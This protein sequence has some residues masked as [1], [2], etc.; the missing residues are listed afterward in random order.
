MK[1]K[2]FG[3]AALVAF[4]LFGASCNEQKQ[5]EFDFDSVTQEVTVSAKVTY[6]AGV[7]IDPNNPKSY[8]MANAEPAQF[9][10]VFIEI[11]YA[12]Y[13]AGAVGNRIFEAVTDSAGMFTISVPTKSTGVLGTIRLEEF[14]AV[15]QD[16][17][18]MGDD[19]KPIF[20]VKIY[21]FSTP[22][23]L[24]VDPVTG[25]PVQF[26]LMPGA[27]T[28]PDNNDVCYKGEPVDE[29]AYDEQ[30]TIAGTVNL[31]YET[32]YRQGAFKTGKDAIVEFKIHYDGMVDA[33]NNPVYLTFGATTD[34]NG[35]Y[36]IT[37]P[38]KSLSQG[39][40][41]NDIKVLGVGQNEFKHWTDSVTS[42]TVPGAYKTAKNNIFSAGAG[43]DKQF[44]EVIG[45]ITYDLGVKNLAFKPY[46]NG[47]I[48][49]NTP[50]PENWDANLVGWAAANFDESYNKTVKF[51]G[52]I[53]LPVLDSYGVGSYKP[54]KQEFTLTSAVAPFNNLDA[55]NTP[56][57]YTLVTDK[58]GYFSIDLPVQDETIDPLFVIALKE[59]QQPFAFIN[60]KEE[61][62]IYSQGN[63]VYKTTVPTR[64][65]PKWYDVGNVY[66]QYVPNA[67]EQTDEW[68]A[69]IYGWYVDPDF[70]ETVKVTGKMLFAYE[71]AY[72]TGD[73]KSL[74]KLV[75]V[76]DNTG[77]PAVPARFF[78]VMPKADGSF[79]FDLPV[80]DKNAARNLQVMNT[81]AGNTDYKVYDYVH[82]P[83]YGANEQPRALEGTYI[84]KHNVFESGEERDS[85]NVLGTYYM[86]IAHNGIQNTLDSDCDTYYDD[87]AGWLIGGYD[88]NL[89]GQTIRM[90]EHATATGLVKMAQE[91]AYMEGAMN[92]AQNLLVPVLVGADQ[93]RVLTDNTGKFSF[94]VYFKNE[95]TQPALAVPALTPIAVEDYLHYED[96][97][98]KTVVLTG[99]YNGEQITK[100]DGE[101]N[102]YGTIYYKFTPDVAPAN[103]NYTKDIAA[104]N[105]QQDYEITKTVTG[106]IKLAK[107]TAYLK[108]NYQT[109]KDIPVK[110]YWDLNNNGVA[111][112]GEPVYI[113]KTDENGKFTISVPVEKDTDE[114]NIKITDL[115]FQYDKFNHYEDGKATA[116]KVLKGNYNGQQIRDEEAAWNDMGTIYY[117]FTPTNDPGAVWANTTQYIAGWVYKQNF[118]I[119]KTVTGKVYLAKETSF[120]VGNYQTEANI[121][122]KVQVGVGL[123]AITYA[124]PTA[125]DGSFSIPVIVEQENDEPAV[126]VLDMGYLVGDGFTYKNFT[127]YINAENK[128]K[129]YD[130]KYKGQ[131]ILPA[132][133]QWN[134]AGTVYYTF[135]PD[136]A[137]SVENWNNYTKYLAGW[138]INAG[139]DVTKNVTGYVKMA[140]ETGFLKGNYADGKNIP[141]KIYWDVNGNGVYNNGIDVY[142]V[143][144]TNAQGKFTIPVKLQKED[145]E[146]DIE[147]ELPDIEENKF[148]HYADATKTKELTGD[149]EGEQ[150]KENNAEWN[151]A[152]TIYYTFDPDVPVTPDEWNT[153]TRYIAGWTYKQGYNTTKTVKG[154]V[155]VAQETA[156]LKG[157]YNKSANNVPVKVLWDINGNGVA[158]LGE[159]IFVAPTDAQGKFEIPIKVKDDED[160]QNVVLLNLAAHPYKQFVHYTTK[161]TETLVGNYN[162]TQVKLDAEDEWN[163]A[164]TVYDAGT[165]YYKF[166]PTNDPG[167]VWANTTQYIAGWFYKKGFETPKT[168]TGYIKLAKETGYLLGEYTGQKNVAVKIQLD[169]D[170]SQTY[171]APTISDDG[172]FEVPVLV[173]N[174]DDEPGVALL[175]NAIDIDNFKHYADAK[176]TIKTLAGTYNGTQI[177]DAD[178]AW[179]EY[180]TE[181]YKFTPDNTIPGNKPA[182]W[183]SQLQY[184]A[185]WF[186]KEGY[187]VTKPVGGNLIFVQETGYLKGDL[188]GDPEKKLV[189][190]KVNNDDNRQYVVPAN[191]D[192]T[193]SVN[194]HVQDINDEPS[195]AI[196]ISAIAESNFIDYVNV[197]NKTQVLNGNYRGQLIRKDGS[198]W[199]QLGTVYYT[200]DPNGAGTGDDPA[201]WT[202]YT[203]HISGWF[204][205]DGF[206]DNNVIVSGAVLLAQEKSFWKGD[207]GGDANGIPVK[208]LMDLDKDGVADDGEPYFVTS[209][210]NGAFN[211]KIMTKDID[212][213]YDLIW[214]S[215]PLTLA[216]LNDRKFVHYY[217]PGTSD[218]LNIGGSFTDAGTINDPEHA[219]NELGTRYYTFSKSGVVENWNTLI[220]GWHVW[221]YNYNET[222]TVT[223]AIAIAAETEP[224]EGG[225]NAK[226]TWTPAKRVFADI[227]VDGTPFRVVTE[228]DGSFSVNIK[229]SIVPP[230]TPP[231]NVSLTITPDAI[232]GEETFKH[233]TDKTKPSTKMNVAGG[234]TS[235]GNVNPALVSRVGET[236]AY[237]LREAAPYS[238]KLYFNPT[239]APTG[240]AQYDWASI[241]NNKD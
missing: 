162:G 135:Y 58:N 81:G 158:N 51:A 75:T 127:H 79:D 52:R 123:N 121:P 33:L 188:K 29:E 205:R 163:D 144:I 114:P 199:A 122:V 41:I 65:D 23:E 157:D 109:E 183:D 117:K 177:Q 128:T 16:Y 40:D 187:N 94:E 24:A 126:N 178:P 226:A 145:D 120:M 239:S 170:A 9:K 30:V 110:L 44:N 213:K 74:K 218:H 230:A 71:T 233:W 129:V 14:T 165:I 231:A 209:T 92:P 93:I 179:N 2:L 43:P 101:W 111:N 207:F 54:T 21:T 222:L 66:F 175:S 7:K 119:A 18:R 149:Y 98:G 136:D 224:V 212:D 4:I 28:F 148:K 130:G 139:Y 95:G 225:A 196:V 22:D 174:A 96:A 31:A 232:A 191:A 227:T 137:A 181:M 160:K 198:S 133:H 180:G 60:S 78:A 115:A 32:G 159:P 151:D 185:G 143:G 64:V 124:A 171:V 27:F 201:F 168:V 184:I 134:E 125:A 89:Q 69:N 26:T 216:D 164:A 146:L 237:D 67:G 235:A 240:W 76:R 48:L 236:N 166:T 150:I 36:S 50:E 25:G 211:M 3:A 57:P 82:Y 234:Y 116:P 156:F 87:L 37:L 195:V 17:D 214:V 97:E 140:Q 194:I 106:Y 193:F 90:T 202:N 203:K 155:K 73:Y 100:K 152:G 72:G 219:W 221:P 182:N 103:W 200:F 197:Q 228:D 83:K 238:A 35:H 108:G 173:E 113:G 38:M 84:L 19:G 99:N 190:I 223:G 107:E 206:K 61:K 204:Y 88:A 229:K 154:Q 176:G 62:S 215:T 55:N 63:Y 210:T 104:W 169:G 59:P 172:K 46:Y 6:D 13:S 12:Q 15:H 208:V 132:V 1:Q 70:K 161:G 80:K 77:A 138:Y 217:R 8:L 91:T 186:F 42:V 49:A 53:F 39:F 34:E 220:D 189:Q 10:K 147:V 105:Y 85:W 20:K 167:N 47:D 68:N 153:Y 241:K 131:C 45:G 118:N 5:S 142:F 102:D 86:F 141:V 192:G 112:N 56:H 11:P